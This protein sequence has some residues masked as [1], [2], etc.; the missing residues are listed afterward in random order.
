GRVAKE[1][2][3]DGERRRRERARRDDGDVDGL[4]RRLLGDRED[5]DQS[6]IVR[7]AARD[8]AAEEVVLVDD[9]DPLR[10]ARGAGLGIL[11]VV[12]RE[13]GRAHRHMGPPQVTLGRRPG[14]L[15][16]Q[17]ALWDQYSP[18]GD[19][20]NEVPES[21]AKPQRRLPTSTSSAS[22]DNVRTGGTAVRDGQTRSRTSTGC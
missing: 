18:L 22:P 5:H 17:M 13:A 21:D 14:A 11:V 10:L 20:S 1:D 7:Q 4:V 9:A 3:R 6:G 2:D 15:F 8:A 12:R 16:G 19:V